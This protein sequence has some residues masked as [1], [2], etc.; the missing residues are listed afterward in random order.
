MRDIFM[1]YELI[2]LVFWRKTERREEAKPVA[3]NIESHARDSF[4]FFIVSDRSGNVSQKIM[5]SF[6]FHNIWNFAL[7]DHELETF[8]KGFLEDCSKL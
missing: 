7:D 5:F 2:F 6:E 4:F 8:T 3:Y 1:R